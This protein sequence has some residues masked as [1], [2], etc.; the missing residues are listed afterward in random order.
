[1]C[2]KRVAGFIIL[3]LLSGLAFALAGGPAD[4]RR[5]AYV[6]NLMSHTVSVIDLD[7]GEKLRD[8]SLGRFPIFSSLHP[9]DATKMILALHNYERTEDDD[10]LLLVDLKT[11]KI[12]KR[13]VFPGAGIPSGFVYDEKRNRFYIADENLHKVFALDGTTLEILFDLP[14]G[15]IPLHVDISPD[16]RWLV[17]TNRKSAN[18]YLYDLDNARHEAKNGICVIPLGPAPGVAWDPDETGKDV[19]SHPVDVKFGASPDLCYVTDFNARTLLAVDIRKRAVV[20]SLPLG[21]APFG[22]TVNRARDTGYVCLIDGDAIAVVNLDKMK[23]AGEIAGVGPEPINC[24]LDEERGQLVVASWGGFE[25]G[26]I[27][28]VDLKSRKIIKSVMPPGAKASI[29]ITIVR[30]P[31]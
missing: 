5:L 17:A 12:L 28:I 10:Q 13:A 8:L 25:T 31:D 14:G 20:A 18:L 27:H 15:L 6:S 21:R 3:G 11:D 16:G 9:R 30:L 24:E 23:L 1:M 22:L 29:G 4:P 2:K 19:T 7:R 26:G